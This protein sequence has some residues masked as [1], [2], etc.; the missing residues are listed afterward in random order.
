MNQ[1]RPI[2]NIIMPFIV[3]GVGIAIGVAILMVLAYIFLWGLGIGLV[4]W[5][6]MTI[7]NRF[8]PNKTKVTQSGVTIEHQ[9]LP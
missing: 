2:I 3:A 5:L 4:L 9:D 7:K 1:Q 8:F 6:I